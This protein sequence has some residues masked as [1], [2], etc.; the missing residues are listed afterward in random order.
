M[1]LSPHEDKLRNQHRRTYEHLEANQVAKKKSLPLKADGRIATFSIEEGHKN[2]EPIV[3]V[4]GSSKLQR[5]EWIDVGNPGNDIRFTILTLADDD[6]IAVG[7][8]V[9]GI[10]LFRRMH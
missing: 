8:E 6:P 2:D 1:F 10:L 9:S 3:V 4:G 5:T 7:T